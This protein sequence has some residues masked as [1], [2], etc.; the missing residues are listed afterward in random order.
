[1]SVAGDLSAVVEIVEHAELQSER[2]L[3]GRDVGAVERERWV[4]VAD[5]QITEHLII[6]AVLFNNVDDVLD[7]I[8]AAW[9]LDRSRIVVQQVVVFDGAGEFFELAESGWNVQLCDRATQ[10]SW[11]V[12]MTVMFDLIG[13]LAHAF[14][15][16]R[17]LAF[18]GGD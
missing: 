17:A 18:G 5:S 13:G 6:G 2:V 3:V 1:M 12:R 9:K 4:A 8:L 7:G 10:Q 14:V 16:A 11:N 15:W